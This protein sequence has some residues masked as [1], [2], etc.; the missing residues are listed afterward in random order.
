M[1]DLSNS[2]SPGDFRNLQSTINLTSFDLQKEERKD[3]ESIKIG[4]YELAVCF[5]EDYIHI[6]SVPG[7]D[8][9]F[10]RLSDLDNFCPMKRLGVINLKNGDYSRKFIYHLKKL[11]SLQDIQLIK[12]RSFK[13]KGRRLVLSYYCKGLGRFLLDFYQDKNKVND[14]Y[15]D[16]ISEFENDPEEDSKNSEEQEKEIQEQLL[17]LAKSGGLGDVKNTFPSF[18]TWN[19]MRYHVENVLKES[20]P[21]WLK[22]LT[23]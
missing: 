20:A 4:G 16:I 7:T 9:Y 19:D 8:D 22:N 23:E 10:R 11:L 17:Q 18:E 1:T 15:L 5:Y 2:Y 6:F 3:L 14:K 21:A 13:K 12:F